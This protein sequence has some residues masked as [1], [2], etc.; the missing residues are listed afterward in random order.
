MRPGFGN[1]YSVEWADSLMSSLCSLPTTPAGAENHKLMVLSIE[2][3]VDLEVFDSK[4]A[5]HTKGHGIMFTMT[6]V[7]LPKYYE[8]YKRLILPQERKAAS[9]Y[10]SRAEQF[11]WCS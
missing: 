7:F 8:N 6:T 3:Y 10:K 9:V 1:M 4:Y 11:F 2:V 5:L